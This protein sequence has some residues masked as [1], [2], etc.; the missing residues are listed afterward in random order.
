M[1]LTSGLD[2]QS[3]CPG[4]T[5]FSL[6]FLLD[7]STMSFRHVAAQ[8]ACLEKSPVNQDSM[9]CIK[10]FP[11]ECGNC[12]LLLISGLF[13]CEK[14]KSHQY[15]FHFVLN[16]NQEALL[17]MGCN[18]CTVST[19]IFHSTPTGSRLCWRSSSFMPNN[20]QEFLEAQITPDIHGATG[21]PSYFHRTDWKECS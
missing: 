2:P 19:M 21:R 4:F 9:A 16:C 8:M 14:R 7:T 12:C 3:C 5:C 10:Q 6:C 20:T 15:L 11:V 17:I 13:V 18:Y 1:N